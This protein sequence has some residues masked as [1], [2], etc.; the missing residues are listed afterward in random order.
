[1]LHPRVKERVSLRHH[2]TFHLDVKARYFAEVSSVP[3]L[4]ALLADRARDERILVLGRGANILFRGDFDGLVLKPRLMGRRIVAEDSGSVVL[5]IGAGED[6]PRLV[7]DVVALGLGGI[8]NLAM[9]PGTV[10][11]APVQH[12]ACYGHNLR[13]VF[14]SLEALS[15]QD[16]SSR[17]LGLEECGFRYRDSVF[18]QSLHGRYLITGVRLRLSKK[19]VLNTS[20]VS[21]YESLEGE[22]SKF[23][24]PPYTVSDVYRAVV[25]IRRRKLPD[26]KRVGCAGSFFKN[27]VVS[28]GEF[29]ALRRNCPS[30]QFYPADQLSY[31]ARGESSL[32]DEPWV[33]IPAGWLVDELGWK[34]RRVGEC[35]LWPK[36]SLNVVNY[37]NASPPELLDFVES[38]R[39]EVFRSYGITLEN[40][41]EVV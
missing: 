34:G 35:G 24:R 8:E 19:P 16:G 13:D 17:V 37:G 33:K 21:R 3:S 10:G 39:A 4:Q 20:Y 9:V 31:P 6:W 5:E 12:I 32:P 36:Q 22:L 2:N 38:V 25:R 28:R 7:A 11:A 23:A 14:V 15:L 41:V 27:P 30:L 18:R 29:L 1:M 40:E 26:L